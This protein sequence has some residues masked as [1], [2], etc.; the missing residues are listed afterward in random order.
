MCTGGQLSDLHYLPPLKQGSNG[1]SVREQLIYLSTPET[2][3][4][5]VNAY[6]GTSTA[7]IPF[8]ISNTNPATHDTGDRDNG[9]TMVRIQDTGVII[10][11]AGLRFEGPGGQKFY[12]NYRG[13]SGAQSTSLTS[14]GRQALGTAFKWGGAPNYGTTNEQGTSLG[15]MATEATTTVDIFGYDPNCEFRE[16]NDKDGLTA[17]TIQVVLK[18]G[19][20]YVL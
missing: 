10:N 19:E 2:T 20:S 7:A 18:A 15:I 8:T 6:I 11:S 1:G 12:V 16:G 4:F 5:T 17:N 13:S 14:K 3:P 9:I